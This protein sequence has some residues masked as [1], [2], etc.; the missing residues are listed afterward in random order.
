MSCRSLPSNWFF[1]FR[2]RITFFWEA[3][4]A[5]QSHPTASAGDRFQSSNKCLT[6]VDG[7]WSFHTRLL[8][9]NLPATQNRSV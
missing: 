3:F 8:C 2:H 5:W 4:M 6:A 1:S 9:C 7:L